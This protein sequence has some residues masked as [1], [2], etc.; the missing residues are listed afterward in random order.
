MPFRQWLFVVAMTAIVA[1]I[2]AKER[3]WPPITPPYNAEYYRSS[4]SR[5]EH[6][7]NKNSPSE[8][9]WK[10]FVEDRVAFATFLLAG[11]TLFLAVSTAALCFITA[12]GM[13][14]QSLDM[15]K[16]ISIAERSLVEL[17]RPWLFLE[18]VAIRRDRPPS[19]PNRWYICLHWRNVGRMPAINKGCTIK[20]QDIETL[21]DEPDYAHSGPLSCEYSVPADGRF[22]TNEAGPGANLVKPDGSPTCFIAY[23][24]L[25]YQELN[26][27]RHHTGFAVEVSAFIPAASPYPNEAY[28]QYD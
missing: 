5:I 22:K 26:G 3:F 21:A 16:S 10:P 24:R 19:E 8:S 11:V 14:H 4:D 13:K 17:E 12:R 25:T 2:G 6:K 1:T 20:F 9:W 15:Q 18:Q 7:D 27:R 28:H 23:G